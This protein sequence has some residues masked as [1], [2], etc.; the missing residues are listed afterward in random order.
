[1]M[2]LVTA[3]PD[4]SS[5]GNHMRIGKLYADPE[6]VMLTSKKMQV[7]VTRTHARLREFKPEPDFLAPQILDRIQSK[8]SA[9]P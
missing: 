6:R 5:R 9:V 1:M 7:K 2:V 3:A 4:S 8:G